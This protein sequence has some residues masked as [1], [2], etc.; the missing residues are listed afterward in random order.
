MSTPP[1]SPPPPTSPPLPESPSTITKRKTRQTTRLRK[2]TS[3]SLDQPRP[4]VNVN[5]VTGRGSSPEKEK[6]YSYLGV[7]A[8]EKIPIVHSSWKVVPESL[9]NLIWDD[10]LDEL[11]EQTTQGTFIPHGMHYIM[12]TALGCEEHPGCVRVAGHG[13][14]I[15]SY[16]GQH[17]SASNSSTPTITPDQLVEIIGN[18]KQEWRK[19]VE[20]KNKK[21]MDIMKKELVAIKT[22]LS[23]IQTQ[24]S[25]PVQSPNPNVLVARVSTKESC[26]KSATNV[27]VGDPCAVQ[28]T[29]M[30]LYVVCGDT[31]QLVA[32]GK[33]YKAGGMIHNVPYA[34]EVVRVSIDTI[35]NGD[36]MVSLLTSEIQYVREA[37]NT[38]VGCL[39]NLVKNLSPMYLD[40]YGRSR[41]DGSVYGFLEPQSIHNAK[42][43]CEQC[44]H[45]I[46][47]W[48]MES[49]RRLA[50][51]QLF[52]LCPRENMVVSAMKTITTSLEGMS[53][54]GPPRWI[55]PKSHVQTEGY[56]CGY[57]VMH[58]M[59]C[60][61]NGGLKDDWKEWFSD[62][63]PLDV[64][65]MKILQKNWATYFLAIRNNR[66]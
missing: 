10:I 29:T 47:T 24:Q 23:Q 35:Y 66:C 57:Y 45:Y 65:A 2:L 38:F 51:W 55:E 56:K 30:G 17:S 25:A 34:D 58:W 52:V 3:R 27:V 1:R 19:E 28:V 7:V 18:L 4:A 49:Q 8:R 33:V 63:S 12:N 36:A 39:T 21:T 14:T 20:D 46:E 40:E 37:M 62:G 64:E 44:Q 15:S 31:T 11:Q 32:L 13:V 60:I 48:V 43:R 6:I 59:W 41:G 42:D 9:K 22:E 26:A 50:H 16:F 54:Q 53:N 5:P 61:V